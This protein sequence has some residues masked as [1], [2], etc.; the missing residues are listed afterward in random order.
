M[1]MQESWHSVC[2]RRD[3]VAEGGVCALVENQQ[4]A[5]FYLP[6]EQPQVYALDNFDPLGGA[7]VLSRGIVGDLQ[8]QLVVAS[9]VYKDHFSLID[10]R[11]LENPVR[12]RVWPVRIAGDQVQ[13]QLPAD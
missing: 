4:V 10:G 3:L 11:C 6:E 9:P 13:V 7:A 8:G 5:I 2:S 12:L 1:S